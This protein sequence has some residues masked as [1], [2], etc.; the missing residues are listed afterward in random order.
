MA[1]RSRRNHS[2]VLKARVALAAVKGERTLAELVEHVDVHPNQIQDW[3][4]LLAKAEY[5]FGAG[6]ANTS[7]H[8][9]MQRQLH[10]KIEQLTM[11]KDV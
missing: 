11:E 7:T 4:Q 5:V 3:K 8:E 9:Q 6:T 1:R 2:P 10:A